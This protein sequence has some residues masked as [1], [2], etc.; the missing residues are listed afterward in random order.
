MRGNCSFTLRRPEG[1]TIHNGNGCLWNQYASPDWEREEWEFS[2][3]IVIFPA[4]MLISSRVGFQP[5]QTS[6]EGKLEWVAERHAS[7]HSD[8]PASLRGQKV[9]FPFRASILISQMVR[10]DTAMVVEYVTGS[11]C[12]QGEDSHRDG[13]GWL[14]YRNTFGIPVVFYAFCS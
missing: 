3:L 12:C 6:E 14:A 8:A 2:R 13:L 11:S 1:K 7:E 9:W 4:N 10:S 5:L